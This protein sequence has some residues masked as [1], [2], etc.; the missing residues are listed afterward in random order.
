M[1]RPSKTRS[2]DAWMNGERV[3]RWTLARG[4]HRFEYDPAWLTSPHAR[5][6]SLSMPLRPAGGPYRTD[7]VQPFFE[8]LLPDSAE[9]RRR[10]MARFGAAT[11]SAF[12]LLEEVGRDCVGAI[13]LLPAGA[14]PPDVRLIRGHPL[15]ESG[16]AEVLAGVR[17]PGMG[18][19]DTD[20][21]RLSLAGAQEKTA[22]LWSKK[23]WTVP[24]S[25]TPTT[26]IFKLPLGRPHPTAI[27]MSTSIENE[28]LCARLLPHFRVPCARS[29]MRTF[30][31]QPVLIVERFDRVLAADGSWIIRLP[32]EDFCQATGTPP[33][34]KYESEGGPG[35]RQIM[36]LLLGSTRA[37]EDRDDFF[38]TQFLFW[39]LC[40][41]DG[42]AK[43]FSVF[44]E[45]GG[46]Y[47]LTPRYDVL[48]AYPVLGRKQHQLSAHK[49][50]MAMAV[51]GK[52]R[53]YRWKDIHADHW[54][55]T[56]RLCGLPGSGRAILND[57]LERAPAAVD[58]VRSV[59]PGGF[60]ATV[61]GPI[62]DGLLAA[63]RRAKREL[64]S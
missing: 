21:F 35:I 59:L 58:A 48:S 47:R 37:L 61:S 41:I 34:Q 7:V 29:E 45:A 62:L 9:I 2:L 15:T 5:P 12:D 20:D 11:T 52:N 33:D 51:F 39:L 36:S 16:V 31:D 43:N 6:L 8:N 64:G 3:G 10:I 23:R 24:E 49:V 22:L 25:T 63:A 53:H 60:P 32:Q 26:H 1:G 17:G 18:A 54:L 38:R 30:R 27:D 19:Q 50:K 13:Q 55:E 42:H 56:G 57:V 46:G 14:P 28:W 4:E 44:I 40:A